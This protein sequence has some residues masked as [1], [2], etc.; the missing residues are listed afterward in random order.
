[1]E[2]GGRAPIN[3]WALR[4]RVGADEQ[5]DLAVDG[6]IATLKNRSFVHATTHAPVI[7]TPRTEKS[8]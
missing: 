1:L 2:P 4:A 6:A 7:A 5:A 3:D 8:G